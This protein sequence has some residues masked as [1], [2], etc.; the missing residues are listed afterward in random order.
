MLYLKFIKFGL[1][2]GSG[3]IIDFFLTWLL[4]EKLHFNKY[5]A[6]SVGFVLAVSNNY[7]LNRIYTFQ[8][9]DSNIGAQFTCFLVIAL[10]G[11]GINM[12]SLYLLQTYTKT[13]FYISKSIITLIVFLWN[14]GA[15]TIYTFK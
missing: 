9:S 4:K 15:N 5:F 10:I 11:F 14:F 3:L 7:I 13:N 6:N 2:G 8:N 1:V 12:L